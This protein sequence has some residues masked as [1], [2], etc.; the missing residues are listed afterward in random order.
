MRKSGG[1]D[2]SGERPVVN[3]D[4]VERG[5]KALSSSLQEGWSRLSG[6][7]KDT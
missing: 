6:R 4:V 5:V 3:W 2:G 7:G 1:P